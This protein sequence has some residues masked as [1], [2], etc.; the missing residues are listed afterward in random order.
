MTVFGQLTSDWRALLR[1]VRVYRRLELTVHGS[2]DPVWLRVNDAPRTPLMAAARVGDGTVV[3]LATA[4][5]SNWTNLPAKP[6]WLPLLHEMLRGVL[7]ESGEPARLAK[8]LVADRPVLGRRWSDVR[9]LIHE[10]VQEESAGVALEPTDDGQILAHGLER[11]GIYTTQPPSSLKL[12]V[13]VDPQ[14]ADTRSLTDRSVAEWFATWSE[15]SW[16]DDGDPGAA[17]KQQVALF[18]ATWP[19]LWLILILIVAETCAARWFS[20][21]TAESGTLPFG[22][23]GAL[24]RR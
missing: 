22:W 23:R 20:H 21:A 24:R 8:V 1:P 12:S 4:I 10:N 3:L 17:L 18:D 19:L 11:P 9:R 5:N 15:P 7:G 6:L 14:A 2:T 16:L 13:N